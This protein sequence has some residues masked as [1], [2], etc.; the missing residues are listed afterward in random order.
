MTG[1]GHQSQVTVDPAQASSRVPAGEVQTR[2]MEPPVTPAPVQA[3]CYAM[4]VIDRLLGHERSPTPEPLPPGWNWVLGNTRVPG[5]LE[6]LLAEAGLLWLTTILPQEQAAL[7]ASI[8][9]AHRNAWPPISFERQIRLPSQTLE[10]VHR[11]RPAYL[12]LNGHQFPL[13]DLGRAVAIHRQS[14]CDVTLVDLSCPPMSPYSESVVVRRDGGVQRIDRLYLPADPEVVQTERNWPAMIILSPKAM[15]RLLE[16]PLPQRLN[17]WPSAMLRLGLRLHGAA[18][19]GLCFDLHQ[20]DSLHQLA[21]HL[22]LQKPAWLTQGRLAEHSPRVWVG[23]DVEIDG[24]AQLVGPIVIGDG[25]HI[26]AHAIVVGPA[27]IGRGTHIGG[28]A[29]VRHACLLPGSVVTSQSAHTP[30]LPSAPVNRP[31][32]LHAVV[33]AGPSRRTERSR[34]IY[35]A[36]KRGM[37]V[38]IALTLLVVTLPLY[39]VIAVAIKINS[40]GPIFYGHVRQGRGGRDFKCWKFRTMVPNADQI[41]TELAAMNEVDGPQFKIRDDPRIFRVGRLLRR[42]NIDEWPQFFNVLIGQMSLVGP[43]PSPERENRMCPAWREARLSVRP[44]ITGLWQ[45]CRKREEETD[46]QEWIYYDMQY[47]KKQ[48]LWLDLKILVWTLRVALRGG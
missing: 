26:G 43:R 13:C 16:T 12:I 33:G 47:V 25:A 29:V 9:A 21:S 8:Q 7:F 44:G 46:F 11:T 42:Y 41:K 14:R 2:R 3:S 18:L 23:K 35:A 38:V 6:G 32:R 4:V 45:V 24:S 10:V 37:D 5:L 36:L 40:P 22:L 1:S 34:R 17:Q 19:P 15:D 30:R 28:D 20:R 48:S 27:V 31:I 39:A